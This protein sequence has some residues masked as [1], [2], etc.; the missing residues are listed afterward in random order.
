MMVVALAVFLAGLALD[1]RVVTG[2]PVWMKPA[3]FALSIAVYAATLAWL[4]SFLRDRRP[5]AVSVV[6]WATAVL[7]GGEIVIIAVQAARGTTS[8]FNNATSLDA[9]LFSAMGAMIAVVWFLAVAAALLLWRYPF[10]D[11][12][13]GRA[14][15]FGVV[16]S[17]LGMAVAFLMTVPRPE[18]IAAGSAILG[19]HSYGVA[20]GGPGLPVVGWSTTG[21]DL[22]IAHF[23][24]MH[25]LQVLPL[26]AWAL[27]RF[28]PSW[29]TE[30]T[31]AR[32]VG[33]AAAGYLGALAILT[34]QALRGQ[35]LLA[36]DAATLLAARA[37]LGAVVVAVG[38]VVAEARRHLP[39]RPPAVA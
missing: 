2:A 15:R 11:R 31:R 35:P 4:L 20:D 23:V 17:L 9:A 18:Q 3:K 21:G 36:P 10:A 29:L 27:V 39:L 5:L 8:H 26:L 38:S 28:G 14:I 32:L 19:A 22:R 37:V 12:A 24:G 30:A 34:W 33:I 7:L 16:V 6:S 13:M 1:P 25:A